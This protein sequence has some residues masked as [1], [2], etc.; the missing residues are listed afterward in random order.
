VKEMWRTIGLAVGL[1]LVTTA[2][3]LAALSGTT[4]KVS[5]TYTLEGVG[6]GPTGPCVAVGQSPRNSQNF[7]TG[8]FAEVK[9]GKPETARHVSGTNDLSRVFCPKK[10]YCIATGYS[11]GASSQKAVFVVID[12]G[13]AGK[14]H[15]LGIGG[16]ASIGCGTASSCWVFGDDYSQ[17][18]AKITPIV[19]HLVDAKVKK[20]FKL[21]GSYSFSAGETG[22]PTPFCSS[23]TSC[24]T[25]G[26]TGFQNGKGLIFSM[27]N[28]KVKILHQVP[29]TSALSAMWCSSESFC[30]FAGYTIKGE[31]ETG[32]VVTMQSG[33][34]GKVY[35]LNLT[36]FPMACANKRS[37]F[38]FG[39]RYNQKTH[40]SAEY[41]IPVK[42]GVPGTP[43]KIQPFVSAATCQ[44]TLCLGAGGVGSF[45]S[46]EG[47][48]F[49][50][51]G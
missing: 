4:H 50:F 12:H 7:S 6:C 22:G 10:N 51:T 2:A 43:Q 45:P 19:V 28:G 9:N 23:A 39:S 14:A 31:T 1:A 41:V 11:F 21:T 49:T 30:R 44:G 33:G 25:A 24:I 15:D 34:V 3:A 47:T 27:N 5:G 38:A 32:A 48:V 35:S 8:V 17:N 13:V 40:Q 20:T 26:T 16:A 46:G 36:V 29:G 42:G 37:C 18:G